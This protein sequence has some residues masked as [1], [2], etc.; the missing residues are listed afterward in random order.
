MNSVQITWNIYGGAYHKLLI[1]YT[2]FR[3]YHRCDN[4]V[5]IISHQIRNGIRNQWIQNVY[6]ENKKIKMNII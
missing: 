6:I 2:N 3:A 1:L 5:D 4:L